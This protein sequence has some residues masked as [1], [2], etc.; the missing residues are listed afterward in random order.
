MTM[1]EGELASALQNCRVDMPGLIASSYVDWTSAL[2]GEAYRLFIGGPMLPFFQRADGE[3]APSFP[4]IYVLDAKLHFASVHAQVQLLSAMRLMPPAYVIGIG[5]AGDESFFAKDAFRRQGDLTP[6]EGGVQEA[7]L[8]A[9]N[10]A[11][12]IVHGGATAF[13][14][15]LTQEVRLALE[16]QFPIDGTDATLLGHSL[17]GLFTSWVLFHRPSAFQRYVIASPSWWWNNYEIWRWESEWARNHSD[18]KASVFAC[19]GGLETATEHRE[20]AVRALT[21][22]TGDGKAAIEATI[23]RSDQCGWMQGAELIPR[24]QATLERRRYPG[25]RLT[26]MVFPDELHESVATLGYSRG[27]RST[28]DD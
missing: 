15:V 13:L 27:L 6:N 17:G 8:K 16:T 7:D 10:F 25:L 1:R 12:G 4:V 18:L 2:N 28:F 3:E 26:T 21:H 22:T 20:I 14:A 24:F 5:Y 11:T 9:M 23:A 19:F